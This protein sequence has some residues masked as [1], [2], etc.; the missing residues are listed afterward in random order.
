MV[1]MI[2]LWMQIR[3]PFENHKEFLQTTSALSLET[4]KEAGCV[5]HRWYHDLED[6]NTF[7]LIEQWDSADHLSNRLLSEGFSILCGALK[8]LGDQHGIQLKIVPQE[9]SRE[10]GKGFS[11]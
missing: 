2:M 7:L 1:F 4:R 5:S 3:V 6:R 11:A 9:V 10:C 8:T